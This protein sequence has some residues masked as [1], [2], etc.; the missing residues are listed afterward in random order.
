[1]S[2]K[3]NMKPSRWNNAIGAVMVVFA[4]ATASYADDWP[5]FRGPT[6][7]GMAVATNLPLTWS[8]TQHVKW[9]VPVP[10]R[11]RSSPVL[12]GD[13]IW[14]TTALETGLRTFN[15]GPNPDRMQQAERVVFGA[16][17]LERST[18]KQLYHAEVLPVDNPVAVNM[19]NSYATPTPVV[20]PG[21]LYCDFGTF[22]TACLDSATGQVLWKRRL[23][24]DHQHGP[25]SSPILYKNL[26][27]LVRDGRDRQ[28]VTA[29]EKE[30]GEIAWKRD[31]P[32]ISTPQEYRKSFSTPLVFAADGRMQMVVPG[33]QWLVAYEP[34]TGKE[35]WRVDDVKGEAVASR[36]VY[37]RGLVYVST[38]IINGRAQ[39]W[40]LRVDG[41]G[42][43][44]KT[45]VAWKL[46]TLIGAMTSPLLV[47]QELYILNDDGFIS[48]VDALTG[49][50][51]G[52]GR[53]G[54]SYAASPVY[55]EGRIYCFSRDG[56]TVV[57]RA[58]KDLTPLAEN[59]LDGPV[60]ASPALVGSAIYLRTDSH[61]YC[62]SAEPARKTD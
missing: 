27:I 30:T 23:A 47:G 59:K 60:F 50:V 20:E 33:A 49:A 16:V 61:L 11:G 2:W 44:T 6:G 28:Y 5:Q 14:L 3:E 58:N 40:A 1:M 12:L 55:A 35:I 8:P 62:L 38:G 17:C 31:R 13:R 39:L 41:Q 42:D 15:E 22:V 10:G 25:G 53:A 18:G 48:C 34:E 7:D 37:G 56:K 51:L 21:R 46:R 36:P 54:G 57:L 9:K 4:G 29:L 43:V 26:L 32:P 19:L 52:K 45:H 24:L